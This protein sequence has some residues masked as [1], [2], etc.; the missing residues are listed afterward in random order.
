MVPA[1]KQFRRAS[2]DERKKRK[3]R[4]S[5]AYLE[6][7]TQP[8]HACIVAWLVDSRACGQVAMEMNL[9]ETAFLQ[10]PDSSNGG[11]DDD[12]ENTFRLRWFTPTNEVDLCGQ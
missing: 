3:K 6:K 4:V 8:Q 9:S 2:E 1:G 5:H 10:R 12:N 11:G 7:G